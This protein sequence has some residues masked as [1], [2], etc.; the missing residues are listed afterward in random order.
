MFLRRGLLAAFTLLTWICIDSEAQQAREVFGKNRIQYRQFDWSYLSGENFDVYYYDARK[1]IATDALHY[2]ESEFDRITDLIGYPPYFKTKVFIYNSLTDLRQSNVGLNHTFFNVGGETEFI[3]PYVEVAHMGTAQEFKEELLFKISD[4]MLNE[5]MF[6]GNLKD[7][8]QSSILMNLPDWFV[9]GASLYVAKG[10]SADMDDYIRQ[11]IRTR[12]A[13][14]AT[15]LEGKDA[16]LVGQSIWNFIAEKYGKSSVANILNYTRVTRNEEKSV[17][18][19]LGISFRQLLAE[20]QKFYSDMEKVQS[21]SYTTPGDS[22]TF[23]ARHNK[24]TEFTTLKISPDGR[25]L[26]Y[27]ENDRGRYIVKVRALNNGKEKIILAG[28]SKVINQRVDYRLPLIAWADVNTLGVIA[29]KNGQYVFWLYDLSSKSKVPRELERF[30]NIRSMEFSSNG[31]LLILSADFEGK[32]D[33]FLLSTRRDRVRRLTNDLYDDLDPTFIPNSNRILFSSNRHTDTLR[34]NTKPQFEKLTDNYNLFIFDLDSTNLLLTRVTNTLSKDYSPKALDEFNFYYLS[35]QR[36]IINLFRFNRATGIYSQVTNYAA[37]IKDYD[38]N[39]NTNT[40]ALIANKNLK[41][42]IFVEE[43]FNY[44]KQ[45]FTPATR[46]KELQQA[47][48]VKERRAKQSG[49]NKT[50]SIRDLLNARLKEAQRPAATDSTQVPTDTTH[51]NVD[52]VVHRPASDTIPKDSI[53]TTPSDTTKVA[54]KT[55]ETVNTDNY[56]FEDD[57]VKQKQPSE[58]F[59]TR[60]MKARDKSRVTGPYPYETKFSANNLVTSLVVDPL[61]GLG[62]SIETQM[63]DMLESYRFY[64]GI[65]TKIDLQ[66][67]DVYG[68]FQYLPSLID[69]A[70]RF[71]RKAIRWSAEPSESGGSSRLFHYSLNRF[72]VSASLPISD[73]IRFTLKPFAA[74]ARTVDLGYA[75]YTSNTTP[76]SVIPVNNYYA[77]FKSEIVYD[78]SVSTGL[79]LIEGSRGKIMF[80][81]YQG[82]KDQ[83]LSFSQASIDLRH[84]QKIYK[85]I[86]FAVRGFAGTFF[87]PSPKLYLLGGMDNWLFNKRHIDGKTSD[88]TPN[89]L[90]YPNATQDLLFTEFATSLRGFNYATLFGNSVMMA[91][92]ELRIPIIRALSNGPIS[93]NFLRHMQLIGFYDIGTSWSG[94]PP[95]SSDNSVSYEEVVSGPFKAQIKNYINPWLYSYGVGART[96]LLGYYVKADLA[97]PVENYQVGKPRVFVTLGFD[98]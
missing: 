10:W 59:L 49:E 61:R 39:F 83:N 5:M 16:A 11:L 84:Y 86:V 27:A 21:Q 68:E 19:T 71:D 73:R 7:M 82:L 88:G 43:G 95:F 17:L 33:L 93:S 50:M 23:T 8:F 13:R 37:G 31:R 26:A 65:M 98:F 6:G 89:P 3:K 4:L 42:N 12:K 60:Y 92:A 45:I 30:S 67:S 14:R 80:Q 35:D 66:G 29:V 56:V 34:S 24:T 62:V 32:S 70:V 77:G 25:Y 87:G 78:N 44:N 69:F 40:F 46:R 9:N 36:G 76:P 74:L 15:K 72:E 90:G 47:R 64:G 97:W 96:V 1:A 91:N 18:I 41:E 52:S 63:N 38:L 79:N 55:P 81:H 53:Q 28:G 2:L 58:S 20:W 85:E 57:V 22:T 54:N 51:V 94:K 48:V 75:D